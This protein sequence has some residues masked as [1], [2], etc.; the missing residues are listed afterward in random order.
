MNLIRGEKKNF[1]DNIGARD[2]TDKKAFWKTVKQVKQV[3]YN[4]NLK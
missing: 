1:F 2:L 4:Q 3:R